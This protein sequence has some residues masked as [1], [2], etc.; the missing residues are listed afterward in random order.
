MPTLTTAQHPAELHYTDTRGPGR[1]IVL[2]HGWPSSAQSW[3]QIAPALLD[4]GCRV[5]S[6]DR[7]GFGHSSQPET[8]Y[9][10]DTFAADLDALLTELDLVD[11]V[12]VGFSMG[13]GEVARYLARYGTGRVTGACFVGAITPCLDATLPDNPDG[14]FTPDAAAA[15]QQGLQAD[16]EGFLA[17]FLVNFYAVAGDGEPQLMVPREQIVSSIEIA[18]QAS[19]A[20]LSACIPLWLTDFR[21][22][23]AAVGVPTL[24]I[25]G[26]GDQIVPVE[27]SGNRMTQFVPQATTVVITAGPH[28]LLASHPDQVSKAILEFLA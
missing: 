13:G 3:A 14:A 4:A 9:D 24:V 5:I 21:A 15:M 12:L 23:L 19:V 6:Y 17:E 8:G 18:N 25:H 27:A 7:R 16:L 22:D 26:D 1:P 28:G 10:Y 2:I 11:A 20:A